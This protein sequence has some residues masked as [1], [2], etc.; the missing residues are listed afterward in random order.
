M[1][2]RSSRLVLALCA[3]L[4]NH[5]YAADQFSVSPQ[6]LQNLG[7]TLSTLSPSSSS[8]LSVSY[9]AKVILMPDQ[10]QVVSSALNALVTQVM[11]QD[12]MAVKAGQPLLRLQ[13][14]ELSSLQLNLAQAA[15]QSRLAQA[16]WARE[17]ELFTTGITPQRR[18]LEAESARQQAD[19]ALTQSRVALQLAGMTSAA[20]QRLEK[21]GKPESDLLIVAPTAGVINA[22]SIHPG[23]RVQPTDALLHLIRPTLAWVEIQLPIATA[24]RYRPGITLQVGDPAINAK[25][26]S[27]SPVAGGTQTVSA[28]AQLLSKPS[29]PWLPGTVLSAKLPVI[30]GAWLLPQAAITRQGAQ[31]YIF[32]RSKEGF[33]ARP[34]TVSATSGQLVRVK[35]PLKAGEQ[36]A[37]SNIIAL[38]GIW[39]GESGMEEE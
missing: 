37:V 9:P 31:A 32:V 18:L 24:N 1:L 36:V 21:G 11:V 23:Q 2:F 34:V 16:A 17:Q 4:A 22:M 8:S 14:P 26:V 6:Q 33:D 35:G 25:L 19:A 13:S 28:R 5:A 29:Q 39:L 20:I 3:V 12:G 10:E 15:S 7:I 38:K 27:L 30:G